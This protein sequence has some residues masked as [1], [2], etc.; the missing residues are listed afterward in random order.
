VGAADR[1]ASHKVTEL[2]SVLDGNQFE[3]QWDKPVVF[4]LVSD[5]PPNTRHLRIVVRDMQ[6]GH[7]GS[8]DLPKESLPFR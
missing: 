7:I 3:R 5:L 8:T 1:V 4:N 6:N 2:E